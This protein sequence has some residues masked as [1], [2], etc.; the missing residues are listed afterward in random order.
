M[1]RCTWNPDF[2]RTTGIPNANRW[3]GYTILWKACLDFDPFQKGFISN[4]NRNLQRAWQALEDAQ[5]FL[6]TK[7]IFLFKAEVLRQIL[8][9]NAAF[10]PFPSQ[11]LKVVMGELL[12]SFEY[13]TPALPQPRGGAYPRGPFEAL[14]R[15]KTQLNEKGLHVTIR[16]F[17]GRDSESPSSSFPGES[18][19]DR[20]SDGDDGEGGNEFHRVPEEKAE[21]LALDHGSFGNSGLQ[22]AVVNTESAEDDMDGSGYQVEEAPQRE[23]GVQDEEERD[24]RL[25]FHFSEATKNEEREEPQGL[26]GRF[27]TVLSPKRPLHEAEEEG[28]SK[29][30]RVEEVD[31]SGSSTETADDFSDEEK[32]EDR[33]SLALPSAFFKKK[34]VVL[35]RGALKRRDDEIVRLHNEGLSC[36]QIVERLKD[37][38]PNLQKSMVAAS[39]RRAGVVT[40]RAPVTQRM[41][42]ADRAQVI[43]LYEKKLASKNASFREEIMEETGFTIKQVDGAIKKYRKETGL[44]LPSKP[45]AQKIKEKEEKKATILALYEIQKTEADKI[46]GKKKTIDLSKVAAEAKVPLSYVFKMI[47]QAKKEGK[48]DTFLKRLTPDQTENL[49]RFISRNQASMS[50]EGMAE[51]FN[52][53]YFDGKKIVNAARVRKLSQEIQRLSK[54]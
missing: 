21:M 53:E 41:S 3:M 40:K 51:A 38:F 29:A 54:Q 28:S 49:K 20:D 27:P 11:D 7:S 33:S 34:I 50:L 8:M 44:S 25:P 5:T 23:E 48:A 18:G 35:S 4:N 15:T 19:F 14:S 16:A 43:E 47:H 9:Y 52:T 45:M 32:E 37:N 24:D 2:L 26:L 30:S 17:L 36:S 31:E 12:V 42:D 6:T 10:N 13:V 22:Q 39:L 1:G 46:K